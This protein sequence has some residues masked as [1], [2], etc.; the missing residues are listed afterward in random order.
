MTSIDADELPVGFVRVDASGIVVES[1][2]AFRDWTECPSP[3]GR[4]ISDFL[5]SVDD[6]LDATSSGMMAR[7]DRSDRAAFMIAA[8]DGLSFTIVDSSERYAAGR[9]LRTAQEMA[10]R[11][12]K[13]LQLIIDSSIA[14]ARAAGAVGR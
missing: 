3:E 10:D 13:R 5:V 7:P 11:T 8:D 2:A 9:R 1:N 14:F 4:P 12:Q 6:F